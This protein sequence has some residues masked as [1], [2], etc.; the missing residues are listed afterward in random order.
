V[1]CTKRCF[2][3]LLRQLPEKE[4]C[5]QDW[6]WRIT[7][8]TCAEGPEPITQHS[9]SLHL[10][11]ETSAAGHATSESA[12]MPKLS[13]QGSMDRHWAASHLTRRRENQAAER[14]TS[15]WRPLTM[16]CSKTPSVQ[17]HGPDAKFAS[18][19]A[20]NRRRVARRR[21]DVAKVPPQTRHHPICLVSL[22]SDHL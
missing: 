9:W 7:T 17:T 11:T 21:P 6:D 3:Q 15:R 14:Q 2:E 16:L 20:L 19:R 10:P 8:I 5:N 22:R 12:R 13:R 1:D 18:R 4:A